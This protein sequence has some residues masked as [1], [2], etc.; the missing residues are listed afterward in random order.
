[1]VMHVA[2]PLVLLVPWQGLS[3]L[4]LH[5]QSSLQ[6]PPPPL[7]TTGHWLGWPRSWAP[8]CACLQVCVC[9]HTC[10]FALSSTCQYI[11]PH[12]KPLC[13]SSHG[14]FPTFRNNCRGR[15]EVVK[16]KQA[17]HFPAQGRVP[18]LPVLPSS[19][20]WD[21]VGEGSPWLAE[22]HLPGRW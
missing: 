19:W 14:Y 15:W 11:H 16:C 12:V 8:L 17:C 4:P 18:P 20:K 9:V 22:R 21:E 5:P 13:I 6:G 10:L 1:M 7:L 2:G 3:L